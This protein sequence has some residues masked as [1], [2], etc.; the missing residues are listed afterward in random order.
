[1]P[2]VPVE[3]I[4]AGGIISDFKPYQLKPNQWSGG[5]NVE[6]NDGSVSKIEG[7]LE[8]MKDCPI[9]PWHLATYQEYQT[10]GKQDEDRFFWIAFGLEKI[11]VYNNQSGWSNVTRQ[12]G[13]S[14]V[15]YK[16]IDGSDWKVTQSGAL[17]VATNGVD[18]PQLWPLD[19]TNKVSVDNRFENMQSWVGENTPKETDITCQTVSGFK[20][21]IIACNITREFEDDPVEYV[22]DRMIKWSTQHGHF[23]EPE[24]WNVTDDKFDAGEYELL[25]TPG[26]IV[27]TLPMGESFFIYKTDSVVMANYVGTPW[28]L[29]FKT[30]DPDTGIIAK[31]AVT[32][33]PGGHFFVSFADCYVNNGQSVVPILSGKVRDQMFDDINGVEYDRIFCVTQPHYNEIWACYPTANSDYC[34]KAMVWN[35]KENTFSFRELPN[36]TDA[37]L[38]VSPVSNDP[39]VTWDNI[40]PDP[41][42]PQVYWNALTTMKW[43]S[44]SYENV[45]SN[46]VM[47]S[48]H[49][50]G[51][52]ADPYYKLYRDRFG[53]L[54]DT[55]TMYSYVERTGIDFGDPSSVKHLRAVW[56]KIE[57]KITMPIKVYTGF[58]M[59]TDHPITWE[60]PFLFDPSQQS[61]ISTRTTGKF[62]GIKLETNSDTTWTLSGLEFEFE[63]SGRRGSRQYA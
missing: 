61:K 56:P 33:F 55:E 21:H 41:S 29:S 14:D 22:Q 37:K 4:G 9:Q 8:V 57:T 53:Q 35:Y 44:I 12:S 51:T 40:D 58:Q 46:L 34:D 27:D 19:D 42:I 49:N 59:A 28:I 45:V 18:V 17:L 30:L 23:A 52:D 50:T 31:G 6:F 54:E 36:I 38:G 1:M 47:V 63:N 10:S 24:T 32:E 26:P 39:D 60:G 15:N 20:N 3:D 48:P 7:Y 25:D 13:G 62:I 5:I 43:G 2:L 16:T 11:Y